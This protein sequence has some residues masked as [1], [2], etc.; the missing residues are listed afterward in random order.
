M[1]PAFEDRRH[2]QLIAHELQLE[3]LYRI[4]ADGYDVPDN[5]VRGDE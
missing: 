3:D 1:S 4:A 5:I 2:A